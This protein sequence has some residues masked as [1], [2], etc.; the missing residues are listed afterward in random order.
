MRKGAIDDRAFD[1]LDRHRRVLKIQR[2]GGFAR[3]G[4]DAAREFGEIIGRMEIARS[5]FPIGMI[6]EIVPIRDLVVHRAAHV[7]IGNA[8]IHAA[9]RLI[10]GRLFRERDH[11]FAIMPDAVRCRLIAAIAAIDFQEP[12]Y[13][14]HALSDKPYEPGLRRA[15]SPASGRR[16]HARFLL[17]YSPAA[18]MSVTSS[19]FAIIS[20]SARRYS[21]GMTLRNLP[22]YSSH[23]SRISRARC[24]PVAFA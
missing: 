15:P 21:T 11:E 17:S 20:A 9:R 2:A 8:A 19:S 18:A 24:E 12:C 1:R 14:T 5:L 7:A 4:A 3:R 10:P 13:F 23:F 6:D 16:R 22:L